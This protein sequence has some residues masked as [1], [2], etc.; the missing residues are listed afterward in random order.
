MAA[1][2][3]EKLEK[4]VIDGE[5]GKKPSHADKLVMYCLAQDPVLFHDQHRTGYAR[6]LQN[7]VNVT[8]SIRSRQFKSWLAGLLWQTEQ[9]APGSEA[10]TS[11]RNVLES[12]ALQ[13][14]N[15]HM[16]Y[17]RVAPAEDGIW[18]D[19]T[20]DR[21]RAIKVT[22]D[23]W[24]IVD[25]PPILFCRYSHQKPLPD[26]VQGGN[27]WRFLD[28]VNLKK[29]DEKTRLLL[30]VTIVSYLIP[31]V[32]HVI[33]V[34]Y[35]IQGS[36]KSMVFKL[37]RR[38]IDPSSVETLTMPRDENERVQQ[39][40]HHWCAF[41]DNQTQIPLWTSDTLC[42]AATGGGFTKRELYT[43]DEDIIY[44]FMRCVGINGINI[45]ASRGD[46]LDRS[47]LL[48]LKDIPTDKRREEKVLLAEFEGC[49]AEILGGVLDTLSKALKMYPLVNTP[50]LFRMA[51]YTRWGCAIAQAL[52]K[53]E[54]DFLDAYEVKVNAQIEE[55]AQSSVVATVLLDFM[56]NR[57][58]W[59]DTPSRLYKE[60]IA[61]AKILEIS[62]HQKS[63]PRAPHIL[64]RQL[65]ELIPALGA[66]GITVETEIRTTGGSRRIYIR[67]VTSVPTVTPQKELGASDA[68]DGTSP[69]STTVLPQKEQRIFVK[70][71]DINEVVRIQPLENPL[72]GRCD[73][74]NPRG[75]IDM[76]EYPKD[77]LTYSVETREKKFL[78]CETCGLQI[79]K[80]KRERE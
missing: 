33:L 30:A 45:A 71:F 70:L 15:Q 14:G 6:V 76:T 61:H 50:K 31:E 24:F 9:K 40:A 58:E 42:R 36:G 41:Y 11:A 34:F 19:M 53:T 25:N 51:D 59:E 60:L 54:K 37:I 73:L 28:F 62:T 43:D 4:N 1:K 5:D 77:L 16:L 23:G 48:G 12:M 39:L 69:I 20:D 3:L 75:S 13:D 32:P 2:E 64:V 26:P 7:K 38:L 49:R 17:N 57:A 8:V 74:H 44:E 35:G 46:L 27:I 80:E 52:G 79:K 66:L 55:A 72:T 78:V 47:L 68:S 65:N 22:A 29:D 63:W 67:S 10:L 18:I 21:W 56:T